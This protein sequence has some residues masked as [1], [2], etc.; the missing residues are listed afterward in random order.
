M[1][2]ASVRR[3]PD[4]ASP[5]VRS[6]TDAETRTPPYRVVTERLVMRCW[7]PADAPL[8]K[9]AVD[10]SLD[11]LRPWMPWADDEPQTIPEKV[12]LLRSFRG[13]FD[14]DQDYVYALFDADET[15]IVGGSGLHLR[16]GEGAFEIGYWI[17]ASHVGQGL[18]TE[19]TAALTRVAFDLCGVDRVELRVEPRNLLSARIPERLGYT[20]EGTLRRRLVGRAGEARRDAVVYTM[21]A[22]DPARDELPAGRLEAYDVVGT[23]LL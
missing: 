20:R 14:L 3:R 7:E 9:E 11:H 5:I 12:E 13:Q 10:A 4:E 15:R 2:A 23:R 19:A 1:R 8:L 18:A 6:V 16:V 22:D 21:L 17:R